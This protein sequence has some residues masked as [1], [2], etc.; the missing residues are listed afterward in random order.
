MYTYI[1]AVALSRVIGSQWKETDLSAT[2]VQEIYANFVKVYLT[3]ENPAIPGQVYVDFD[4]LK[5]VYATYARTLSELLV[6]I[7]NMALETV[8]SLPENRTAFVKYS[9]ALRVGYKT[10]L[11]KAGMEYPDTYPQSELPDL[12]IER[13]ARPMDMKLVH[14]YC[15]VSVNGYYHWTSADTGKAYAY[16]GAVSMRKSKINH[17]GLLNFIDIGKLTKIKIDPLNVKRADVDVA[18][19]DKLNF[20]VQEN[21]DNKSYILILGGY[22]V[23]PEDGVF[24]R[25]GEQG[26]TVSLQ[27]LD[28]VER[29]LESNQYLDLSSLGLTKY[30]MNEEA[31]NSAEIMSD[32]VVRKYMTLSQSYL[33]LV[34][35]PNLVSNKIHVRHSNLPGMFTSYQKPQYPLFL[36]YGKTAEYWTSEEDGYWSL[37]VQDS[38]MRN[39]MVSQQPLKLPQAITDQVVTGNPYYH[40]RGYFLELIGYHN[41]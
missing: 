40:S 32:D 35:V 13:P 21:L 9:D 31:L 23:L 18:M 26:F 34:D 14:D 20:S 33:V 16:D 39:Y 36:N 5:T 8:A 24:W 12:C 41:A 11:A 6:E 7:G 19:K 22:M 29:L 15:L 2:V 4:T 3:L 25:S 17:L 30:S 37:T 28:Y 38:F 27:K 1:K 10:T